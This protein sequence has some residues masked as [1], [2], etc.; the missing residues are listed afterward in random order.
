[1][2]FG[3]R[4]PL[5]GEGVGEVAVLTRVQ[6]ALETIDLV[7]DPLLGRLILVLREILELLELVLLQLQPGLVG[8]HG[9]AHGELR[10]HGCDGQPVQS[11][12]DDPVA[13]FAVP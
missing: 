9:P 7:L 13:V 8:A 11:L 3:Q 10:D 12:G 2:D 5:L 4:Q 1:M 6:P